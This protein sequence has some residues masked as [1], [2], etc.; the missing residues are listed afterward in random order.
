[1]RLEQYGKGDIGS[2]CQIVGFSTL[3]AG[4]AY[5]GQE[6]PTLQRELEKSALKFQNRLLDEIAQMMMQARM[7]IPW[8]S[9]P[10]LIT[11]DGVADLYGLYN[12]TRLIAEKSTDPK[13]NSVPPPHGGQK[14]V[15][16]AYR[17]ENEIQRI[18]KL[19][20]QIVICPKCKTMN[21]L[22]LI[23]CVVC[24]TNLDKVKPVRNP[25]L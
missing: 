4:Y 2:Y 3:I 14:P 19:G 13:S 10:H 15:K 24:H 12:S 20:I 18:E 11:M 7:K 16:D 21:S 8:E 5:L 17:P 25:Y 1:M 6:M 22:E 23:E 9:V